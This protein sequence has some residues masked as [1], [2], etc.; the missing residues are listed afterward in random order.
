M[1]TQVS[2]QHEKSEKEFLPSQDLAFPGEM[3]WRSTIPRPT[4]EPAG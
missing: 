3:I 2:T 4:E 1:V